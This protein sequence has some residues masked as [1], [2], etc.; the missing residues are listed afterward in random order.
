MSQRVHGLPDIAIS[1]SCIT[2][3]HIL[4]ARADLNGCARCSAQHVHS[5]HVAQRRIYCSPLMIH[6]A[7]QL[8]P[9]PGPAIRAAWIRP[10]CM[11][12]DSPMRQCPHLTPHRIQSH[13]NS[14]PAALTSR[15][16]LKSRSMFMC[17]WTSARCRFRRALSGSAPCLL[18]TW[19]E[20]PPPP[21]TPSLQPLQHQSSRSWR[22]PLCTFCPAT[23]AP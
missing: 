6:T 12:S 3:M 18:R 22:V 20:S 4:Q 11:A 8:R 17:V 1:M 19:R 23:T 5:C 13:T 2:G 9:R 7:Q 14:K 21:P 10:P 15:S 16:A